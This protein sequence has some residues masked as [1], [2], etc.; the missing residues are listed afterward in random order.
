MRARGKWIE[1]VEF[2][3]KI[4]L[5]IVRHILIVDWNYPLIPHQPYL[6]F[7]FLKNKMILIVK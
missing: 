1:T 6:F 2:E 7:F 5:P 3:I 4:D